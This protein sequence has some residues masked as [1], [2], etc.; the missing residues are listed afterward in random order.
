[1]EHAKTAVITGASRGIGRAIAMEFARAGYDLAICCKTA[2]DALEKTAEDVRAL[3]RSC[4]TFV[5][6][7]GNPA[8]VALFF[9]KIRQNGSS[10]T[11]L[12]NNAGI[13]H[14]G[15][16][17]DMTNKEWDRLLQSN[18]SS[19]FYCCRECV[20]LMLQKQCGKIITISSVWGEIGASMEVAYSATKGGVNALTK[21]LAKELAPSGI[22]VNAVSC[23]YVDTEMNAHLSAEEQQALFAEIPTGRPATP[24]EVAAFVMQIASGG[25][26]LTGQILRLDGGWI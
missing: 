2:A 7:M 11:V 13:S 5:G 1:M 16:I 20:P 17:Q 25:S 4:L 24:E 26:Y 9:E 15:L 14:V 10:V 6:D 22:Q 3:G 12:V 21:A 18:L 8:D 19:V 23:G